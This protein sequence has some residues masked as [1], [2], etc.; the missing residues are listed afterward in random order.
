MA[1]DHFLSRRTLP[2]LIAVLTSG[3][4]MILGGALAYLDSQERHQHAV[5]HELQLVNRLQIQSLQTWR[6]ARL[7]EAAS[8]TMDAL[9]GDAVADW[10]L[11]AQDP[12][13]DAGALR[14]A[15][16]D[17]L[18]FLYEQSG[19]AAAYLLSPSG[20]LLLA[21]EG[22]RP[23][24]LSPDGLAALQL[25]IDRAHP[26]AINPQRDPAFTFPFFS[27]IAP[28]YQDNEI[29]AAV[30]MIMDVR[31]SLFP[32]LEEWPSASQTAESIL[33]MRDRDSVRVLS[34]LRDQADAALQFRMSLALTQ[35]PMAQAVQGMRGLFRGQD[36][37]GRPVLAVAAPVTGS[38]W[39]LVSKID[40]AEALDTRWRDMWHIAAPVIAGLLC[41]WL[42]LGYTQHQAWRRERR[43]KE[44]LERQ[45]RHD[46]L[47]QLAN[48]VAL[49]EQFDINWRHAVRQR[50]PLS[51]L[52]IDVDH[53]KAYNDHFGHIA[54]D[55]CLKQVAAMLSSV[56]RRSTDLV[57]RYGGEEFV[58]L[59]PDTPLYQARALAER[60]CQTVFNAAIAHPLSQH[61]ERVT[62]SVGVTCANAG[63]LSGADAARIR[64]SL[65]ER[66]DAALYAAKSAGRNRAE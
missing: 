45:V 48:R 66:A 18:R 41:I 7:T 59:L 60:I 11:A 62:V 33:V 24:T 16:R 64:K 3:V 42:A 28:V 8:I 17:R 53:F 46:P 38:S 15:I 61:G 30:W 26:V 52:M 5:E 49:N 2:A 65:L 56:A 37:R 47:T 12:R 31:S 50:Q 14:D 19:Y 29:V 44:L 36:Y 55:Q 54:G 40:V 1:H 20:A 10:R 27:M 6:S 21:P 51:V 25:A 63:D 58:M 34:P 9:F 35:A 39:Y 4:L 57:S 23:P 43:L 32:L 22:G 13:A